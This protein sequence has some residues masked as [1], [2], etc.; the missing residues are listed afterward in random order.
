MFSCL[1]ESDMRRLMRKKVLVTCFALLVILLYPFVPLQEPIPENS[2]SF[3]PE[4]QASMWTERTQRNPVEIIHKLP[5][6]PPLDLPRIQH[7]FRPES[8]EARRLRESRLQAVK[9]SFIHTWRGYAKYAWP[10]D[11]LK[12]LSGGSR[13][14]FGNWS[15]TLVDSLDTLLIMDLREE[16]DEAISAVADIDFE[17]S[18]SKTVS[19]FET[20][21]RYLG[22]L[23]AAYDLS[24][25]QLLID[26]AWSL[27]N[28]LYA[29]F[30]TPTRMP[31]PY[32]DWKKSVSYN[33][34]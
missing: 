1:E 22:G 29:A 4:F 34:Q 13:D 3:A 11:E 15:A 27:G 30:D 23:L 26:K 12:P 17:T 2:T 8:L 33:P 25:N 19:V 5:K 20:T 31:V 28:M 24:G 7:D 6:D 14:K 10:N 18:T 16:F 32:W 9:E 21:I